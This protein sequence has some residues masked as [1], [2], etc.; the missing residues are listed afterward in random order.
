MTSKAIVSLLAVLSFSALG[1]SELVASASTTSNNPAAKEISTIYFGKQPKKLGETKLLDLGKKV[2]HADSVMYMVPFGRASVSGPA[3]IAT[4]YR[5]SSGT[6]RW[7]VRPYYLTAYDFTGT[8]QF[9]WYSGKFRG[10][11]VSGFGLHYANASGTVSYNKRHGGYATL[12]GVAT[13]L[14]SN[15]VATVANG[16]RTSL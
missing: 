11:P 15:G 13:G 1:N 4:L 3:G 6:L 5:I 8:V 16:V 12:S 10:Q 7:S 14:N 9:H 2:Q